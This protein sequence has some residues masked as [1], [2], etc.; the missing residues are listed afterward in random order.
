MITATYTISGIK[1]EAQL[2]QLSGVIAA[3]MM[4]ADRDATVLEAFSAHD[5][6]DKPA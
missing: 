5:E 2:M 3:W 1:D 6:N 4:G